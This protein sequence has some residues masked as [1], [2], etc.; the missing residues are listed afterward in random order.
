MMIIDNLPDVIECL[1]PGAKY[2]V[3]N[4][5]TDKISWNDEREMP[6]VGQILAAVD[7]VEDES[8]NQQLRQRIATLDRSM[9]DYIESHY[10]AVR[11]AYFNRLIRQKDVGIEIPDEVMDAINSVWSWVEEVMDHGAKMVRKLKNGKHLVHADVDWISMFDK[12]DPKLSLRDIMK[13][14]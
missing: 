3:R 12:K 4:N 1:V 7:T 2:M 6:T 11:L 9:N 13:E 5:D 14:S 10:P 8:T